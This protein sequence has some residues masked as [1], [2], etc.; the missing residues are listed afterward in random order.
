[1]R[2]IAH[3]T[4]NMGAERVISITMG[5]LPIVLEHQQLCVL[6][7]LCCI[8][9]VLVQLNAHRIVHL[10]T[11]YDVHCTI[12]IVHCTIYIVRCTLYDV[13]HVQTLRCF[14]HCATNTFNP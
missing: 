7:F 6:S 11:L 13:H 3:Y 4:P 8:D 12:Y 5:E 9:L 1:M 14:V 10:S 2:V